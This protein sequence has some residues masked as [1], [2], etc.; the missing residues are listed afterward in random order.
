MFSLASLGPAE[1][2]AQSLFFQ[3]VNKVF[4]PFGVA[5]FAVPFKC[6]YL[7]KTNISVPKEMHIRL[8][9][10]QFRLCLDEDTEINKAA[11][12]YRSIQGPPL[13]TRVESG[14]DLSPE[15][16]YDWTKARGIMFEAKEYIK[17]LR[18]KQ[19]M[20]FF[21]AMMSNDCR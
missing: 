11:E 9:Y 3:S 15:N 17:T 19:G 13:W 20:I 10:D 14:V 8:P 1:Q 5:T 21:H 16:C 6:D 2:K 12:V 18:E 7:W 4:S